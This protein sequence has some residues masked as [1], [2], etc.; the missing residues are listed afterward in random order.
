MVDDRHRRVDELDVALVEDEQHALRAVAALPALR[1]GRVVQPQDRWGGAG[2]QDAPARLDAGGE[3]CERVGGAPL[4]CRAPGGC[5]AR[6][7]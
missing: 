2:L 1:L 6:H 7:G 5:A 3:R 4:V